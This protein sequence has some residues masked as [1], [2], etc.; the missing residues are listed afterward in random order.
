MLNV[1][2]FN[3]GEWKELSIEKS[4]MRKH[5]SPTHSCVTS[6]TNQNSLIN[7][8]DFQ[9]CNCIPVG[10][11]SSPRWQAI[12]PLVA[13]ICHLILT[14]HQKQKVVTVLYMDENNSTETRWG[15]AYCTDVDYRILGLW[16]LTN[17]KSRSIYK[18]N[19]RNTKHVWMCSIK[20]YCATASPLLI[21]GPPFSIS[22]MHIRQT[23]I[24]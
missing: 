3:T 6:D 20:I 21:R 2:V 16:S 5:L 12:F 17:C 23:Y 18:M 11:V 4:S 9:L 19:T 10:Y 22:R 1:T 8:T 14:Y 7:I 24:M 13:S 15:E